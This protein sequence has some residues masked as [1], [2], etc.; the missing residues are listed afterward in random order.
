MDEELRP[1]GC[2]NCGSTDV[3]VRFEKRIILSCG[4]WGAWEDKY[5]WIICKKCG[6]RTTEYKSIMNAHEAW[7]KSKPRK[8]KKRGG[9]KK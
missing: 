2:K 8:R 9:V 4:N 6:F 7:N 5:F 3:E 1:A